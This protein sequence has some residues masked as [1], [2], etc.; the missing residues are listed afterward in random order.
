MTMEAW[1]AVSS[2]W[3]AASSVKELRMQGIEDKYPV[4]CTLSFWKSSSPFR[5]AQSHQPQGAG[6]RS[7]GTARWVLRGSSSGDLSEVWCAG[8]RGDYLG[9]GCVEPG[10]TSHT[11][12]FALRIIDAVCLTPP[13]ASPK[14]WRI[15]LNQKAWGELTW[16]KQPVQRRGCVVV[17]SSSPSPAGWHWAWHK[18][19]N[20]LSFW[21]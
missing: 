21:R 13:S 9:L 15:L 16:V 1:K 10:S 5:H 11:A 19:R 17:W 4:W 12:A 7:P 2:W 6:L 18:V 8:W 20:S 3:P 14:L